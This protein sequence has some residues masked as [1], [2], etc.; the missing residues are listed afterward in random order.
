MSMNRNWDAE[1]GSLCT[2]ESPVGS[3]SATKKA[4]VFVAV[5]FAILLMTGSASAVTC[6]WNGLLSTDWATIGNWDLPCTTPGAGDTVTIGSAT[7]QPTISSAVG[8]VGAITINSGGTLTI[9]TG[10]SITTTSTSTVKGQL[11]ISGGTYTL[12]GASMAA[13]AGT[14][15]ISSGTLNLGSS[16]GNSLDLTSAGVLNVQGGTLVVAGRITSTTG[17]IT[18][19][20]GAINLCT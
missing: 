1:K 17:S 7:N 9:A 5:A 15:L 19:S 4:V 14:V 16:S 8:S 20:N 12:N 10:G 3:R 6:S 18:L 2:S 11:T 13:N